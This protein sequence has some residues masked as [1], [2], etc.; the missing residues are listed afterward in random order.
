MT[1]LL[2]L[3]GPGNWIR[4]LIARAL[5]DLGPWGFII[6]II[7]I[8]I[9]FVIIVTMVIIVIIVVIVICRGRYLGQWVTRRPSRQVGEVDT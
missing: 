4:W 2:D 3:K 1:A 7:V 6:V 5:S 9:I 8:I